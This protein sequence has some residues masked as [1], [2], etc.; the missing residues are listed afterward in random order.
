MRRVPN[1]PFDI[2]FGQDIDRN[3][4]AIWDEHRQSFIHKARPVP[5]HSH[6][7]YWQRIPLFEALGSG[8]V[9]VEA[10]VHLRGS[11]LLVGHK[12]IGLKHDSTLPSMY[13]EPLRRLVEEQN[14]GNDGPLRG[15]FDS[16]PEQTV[17]LLI[18][19]KTSGKE[20]FAELDKQLQ[21]LRDLDYLTYWNGTARISRP[22]TV[23]ASGNAPFDSV[24]ALDSTH[25]DIFWD[26]KLE[27]LPS[28]DDDFNADPV[29]YKYNR[30]N[31]YFASTEF[32]NAILWRYRN[33]TGHIPHTAQGDDIAA[34]QLE[35][36]KARGLLARYWNTPSNPPNV[37]EIAWRV[38]VA[39]DIDILNMDDMG[40]VRARAN[41]WGKSRAL[42]G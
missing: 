15:I 17:V 7:D 23:V 1:D 25:R 11:E 28:I 39:Q 2:L 32:R 4:P 16:A 30:S 3:N 24:M 5:V 12:S 22:I 27:Q 37:Q 8:C 20:T 40:I 14:V 29:V 41:G 21:P 35:Q 33:S 42:A 34:T 31:S 36:A 13:L 9:S 10:D 6:N 19:H 26:A 38:L 18:D